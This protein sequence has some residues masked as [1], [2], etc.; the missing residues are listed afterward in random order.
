M[1]VIRPDGQFTAAADSC[2]DNIGFR[3]KNE[4]VIPGDVQIQLFRRSFSTKDQNHVIG[5][6]SVRLPTENYLNG[7]VSF[8]SIIRKGTVFTVEPNRSL[9]SK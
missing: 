5:F 4:E 8:E 3:V 1:P 6:Y 2:N 9:K 7:M